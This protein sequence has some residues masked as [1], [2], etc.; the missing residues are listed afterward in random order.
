MIK[1]QQRVVVGGRVRE[2][3]GLIVQKAIILGDDL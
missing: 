3:P 2:I 1:Q